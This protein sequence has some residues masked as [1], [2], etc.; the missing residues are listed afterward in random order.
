MEALLAMGM[1]VMEV[2][3]VGLLTSAWVGL[4]DLFSPP[5]TGVGENS[6]PPPHTAM[7]PSPAQAQAQAQLQLQ[8][9]ILVTP[10]PRPGR[11]SWAAGLN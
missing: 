3:P 5:A 9:L 10:G 1:G 7:V 4:P 2:H 11:G 8:Q 6:R